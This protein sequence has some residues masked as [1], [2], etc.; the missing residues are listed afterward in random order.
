MK[1]QT[2]A[3][4]R[5]TLLTQAE[6]TG[7]ANWAANLT[8]LAGGVDEG[9]FASFEWTWLFGRDGALTTK[10][11]AGHWL[12]GCSVPRLAAESILESVEV[13]GTVACFLRPTHAQ[14]VRFVLDKLTPRR[15][16]IVVLPDEAE[17]WTM[18]AC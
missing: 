2:T 7:R 10:D 18:L 8:A 11:V 15:A 16:L 6:S 13:T 1:M 9:A 14:Q 4:E 3:P 17:Y 5:S 12:S